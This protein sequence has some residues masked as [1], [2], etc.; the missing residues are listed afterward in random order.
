MYHSV[1]CSSQSE[2][3]I[4]R[5]SILKDNSAIFLK[6][7]GNK[8]NVVE[9]RRD[10]KG[11][12]EKKEKKVSTFEFRIRQIEISNKKLRRLKVAEMMDLKTEN[13]K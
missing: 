10:N 12:K 2:R 13:S 7:Q 6:K 3:L 4:L 9:L 11:I 1:Y 5:R 8:G